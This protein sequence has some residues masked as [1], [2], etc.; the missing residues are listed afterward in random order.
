MLRLTCKSKI[1]ITTNF[2]KLKFS[3]GLVISWINFR[4][5]YRTESHKNIPFV[6]SSWSISVCRNRQCV[7]E[8]DCRITINQTR[9]FIVIYL[10]LLLTKLQFSSIPEVKLTRITSRRNNCQRREFIYIWHR[11]PNPFCYHNLN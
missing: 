6:L 10:L 4:K 9:C 5:M 8:F 7:F 3:S 2:R 1:L 11:I